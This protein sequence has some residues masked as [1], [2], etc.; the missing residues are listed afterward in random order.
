MF[1][2][3]CYVT[4]PQKKIL[5]PCAIYMQNKLGAAVLQIEEERSSKN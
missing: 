1:Y 5:K 3:L 2:K 4:I